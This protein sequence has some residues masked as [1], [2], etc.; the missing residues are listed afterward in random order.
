[1]GVEV[2]VFSTLIFSKCPILFP[3]ARVVLAKAKE[4]REPKQLGNGDHETSHRG[5]RF[6]VTFGG[7]EALNLN[8]AFRAL[9]DSESTWDGKF[10]VK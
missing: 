2:L 3:T 10:E 7:W 9:Q 8:V 5:Q 6:Y 4:Q 1:M